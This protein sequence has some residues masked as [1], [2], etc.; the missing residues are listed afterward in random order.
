MNISIDRLLYM[1]S[2]VYVLSMYTRTFVV[3]I[4]ISGVM[5]YPVDYLEM[6]CCTNLSYK[7]CLMTVR[8]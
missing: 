5:T 6:L 1:I 2:V 8:L 7:Y 3:Y 4:R